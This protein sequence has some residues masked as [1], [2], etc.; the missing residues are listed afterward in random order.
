MNVRRREF[1]T[2]LG[3]AAAWPVVARAQQR[4]VPVIGALITPSQAEWADRMDEFRLGLGDAGFIEGRNV[5]IEYRWADNQLDR[6]P[7][8]IAD[9]VG[10]KVAVIHVTGDSI[11]SVP[12][13]KAATKAIPIVFTTASDP[14]ARGLVD[15]LNRPGGNV[16]GVTSIGTELGPKQLELLHEVVPGANKIGLLVNPKNP[17]SADAMVQITRAA[18]RRL[19]LEIAVV[20]AGTVEEIELAFATFARQQV[21]AIVLGQD[22][23]FLARREQ[24]AALA[25]RHGM[26]TVSSTRSA[27]EAGALMS[28]GSIDSISRQAGVYVGRILHGASPGDLPIVQPT[29][30][31]LVINLKTAKALGLEIAPLLL[32]RADQVIE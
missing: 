31:E 7:A 4:A 14:V 15:S 2:L 9:L 29:K 13:L 32:A 21:G 12:M 18:A 6:L 30:F 17:R 19:G 22:A 5:V 16:T 28:Y 11:V 3:G 8:L 26:P 24:V 23:F 1:I 20:D 27:A 25:L 10:R